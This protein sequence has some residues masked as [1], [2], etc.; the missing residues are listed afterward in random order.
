[1]G[2]FIEFPLIGSLVSA[3]LKAKFKKYSMMPLSSGLTGAQVAEKM[4]NDYIAYLNEVSQKVAKATGNPAKSY[5]LLALDGKDDPIFFDKEKNREKI[6]GSKT[7][8]FAHLNFDHTPMIASLAFLT[9]K[10][11]KIAT[12]EGE[13]LEQLKSMVGAT[14][15]KFDKVFGMVRAESRVVAAGTK[16]NAEMHI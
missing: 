9:E 4:L 11:A 6:E 1:M 3:R 15:F 2:T 7:K 13:I 8:D 14:D 10:Q 12:Y 16:Y 5:P